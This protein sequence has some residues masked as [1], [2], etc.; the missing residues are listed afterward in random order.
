MEEW[1][2]VSNS[3]GYYLGYQREEKSGLLKERKEEKR[4]MGSTPHLYR[5]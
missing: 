5:L 2:S 4:R 1:I 3:L